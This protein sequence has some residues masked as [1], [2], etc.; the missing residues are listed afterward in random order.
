MALSL[1]M[2][3]EVSRRET[4]ALGVSTEASPLGEVRKLCCRKGSMF[5]DFKCFASRRPELG[6]RPGRRAEASLCPC[7]W[8]GTFLVWQSILGEKVWHSRGPVPRFQFKGDPGS[9]HL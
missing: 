2:K 3:G 7:N 5:P 4:Q 8:T 1:T 9:A 6:G